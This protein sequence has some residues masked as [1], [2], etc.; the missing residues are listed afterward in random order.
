LIVAANKQILSELNL[1]Y[2]NINQPLP[3]IDQSCFNLC[4]ATGDMIVID[5]EIIGVQ[6][7]APAATLVVAILKKRH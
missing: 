1:C 5:A 3:T 6:R 7:K 2:I 4:H